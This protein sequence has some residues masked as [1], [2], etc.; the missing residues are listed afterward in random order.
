[1]LFHLKGWDVAYG[2]ASPRRANLINGFGKCLN[3]G[4]LQQSDCDPNENTMLW[5]WNEVSLG[6]K[7]R[8][9][10]NGHGMCVATPFNSADN[11][12]QITYYHGDEQGQRF[13]LLDSLAHPGFHVIKN[14]HG[15]CLSVKG[16]RN[17]IGAE[18]WVND[19]NSSEGGQ[20]WKWRNL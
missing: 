20:R 6:S 13:Y 17:E 8:H 16:N 18:I 15:K 10:C 12:I 4:S 5:S 3:G 19:C 2:I 1:M 11:S 9:I 7:D 14:D